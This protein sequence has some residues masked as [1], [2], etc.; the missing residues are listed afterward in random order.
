MQSPPSPELNALTFKPRFGASTAREAVNRRTH[1]LAALAGRVAPQVSQSD[2][3]QAKRE[4]SGE[5]EGAR[6]DA[7]LDALDRAES[8]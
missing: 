4:I 7:V 6:Q 8:P 2:Y 1:Q 3:E 5:S